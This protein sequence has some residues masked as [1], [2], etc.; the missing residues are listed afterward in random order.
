MIETK[1]L[2]KLT[3]LNIVNIL[4]IL[5]LDDSLGEPMRALGAVL[6]W[7]VLVT[8]VIVAPWRPRPGRP[9]PE[10]FLVYDQLV[11]LFVHNLVRKKRVI[12][13]VE[14]Y[15][16]ALQGALVQVDDGLFLIVFLSRGQRCIVK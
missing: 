1:A 9:D 4:L 13:V 16:Q 15:Q 8:V 3:F 14:R 2:I 5:K 7:G 6:F 12:L 10:A 11:R